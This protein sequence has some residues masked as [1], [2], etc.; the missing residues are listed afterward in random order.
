MSDDIVA[1]LK[2]AL[3][4]LKITSDAETLTTYGHDWTTYYESRPCAVAFVRSAREVQEVV[5]HAIA[6]QIKLVPSAGRTGLSGGACAT[7]DELVISFELM[8]AISNFNEVDRTVNVQAGVITEALQQ[9]AKAHDLYFPV[10]FASKGSS[11]I[12]GNI[13]TNAGGV[14][15]LKYGL[16]REWVLGLTVVTGT[17]ELLKLNHGLVKNATGYDLRHLM[18]GS[19]GTLG[20]IIDATIQLTD[21]PQAPQVMVMSVP[22][23]A[24]IPQILPCMRDKLSLTAFEFFSDNAL[25]HVVYKHQLQR[26][27]DG[28][29]PYYVLAEY[30]T[31]ND[32]IVME[33]FASCEA[34]GFISDAVISQSES[35][36]H[37][38]WRLREDITESISE[39]KP[40]KNDIAVVPSKMSSFISDLQALIAKHYPE[41]EI[42]LFGHIGDGN[43]HLNILKPDMLDYDQFVK[44]CE[45]VNQLVFELIKNYEGSISAEHGIGLLKKPYLNYSRSDTEIDLM[46]G[47]KQVFDPHGILNPGKL[48]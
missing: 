24:A 42:V 17:G 15:V 23:V 43:L 35:Q 20:F 30:E 22:E 32:E 9:Y 2:K 48:F 46:R 36:A 33:V 18:I 47:I 12:G 11:R 16:M 41:F 34:A 29:A 25:T 38:L 3:P 26:P 4:A 40:Y 6:N 8:D 39:K 45:T 13:A 28:D 44:H 27:F 21:R 37:D 31:C 5:K 14:N 19:E 7:S 10:S 1:I